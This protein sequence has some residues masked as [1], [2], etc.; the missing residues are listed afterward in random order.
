LRKIIIVIAFFVKGQVYL[1]DAEHAMHQKVVSLILLLVVENYYFV[2]TSKF[3]TWSNEV[4]Y[5]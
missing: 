2:Q 5:T 4:K 1:I 3:G